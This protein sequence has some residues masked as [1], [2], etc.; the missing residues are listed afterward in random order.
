M[1]G[2]DKI[3][4]LSDLR[5]SGNIEQNADLVIMLYREAYYL[6]E[7]IKNS[8]KEEIKKIL[9]EKYERIKNKAL[10]S[11][12]KNRNG[13]LADIDLYCDLRY[14]KFNDYI[15]SNEQHNR[16]VYGMGQD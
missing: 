14:S 13:S 11:V 1:Q 7:S 2:A 15:D 10:M 16:N 9:E 4:K 3:P 5:E 12:V 6:R 8:K